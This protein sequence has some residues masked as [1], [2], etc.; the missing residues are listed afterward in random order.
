MSEECL[1]KKLCFEY[2]TAGPSTAYLPTSAVLKMTNT[3]WCNN[4]TICIKKAAH[5]SHGAFSDDLTSFSAV[6]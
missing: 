6:I 1:Q 2:V 3:G 4:L 5:I